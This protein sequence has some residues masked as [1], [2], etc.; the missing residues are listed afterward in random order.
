MFLSSCQILSN[1][2]FFQHHQLT[3]PFFQFYNSYYVNLHIGKEEL[4]MTK[5]LDFHNLWISTKQRWIT[6][7]PTIIVSLFLFLFLLT[8][9]G[10]RLVIMTSFLTLLFQTRHLQDFRLKRLLYTGILM[11]FICLASFLATRNLL[12]C[13]IFNLFVP[14]LVVVLLTNKFNPKAYFIYIMEF[15]FL[16]I[17]PISLKDLPKQLEALTFG[18][19]FVILALYIYSKIIKR[20]RHYGTVR[21]GMKNL[22]IQLEK[23]KNNEDFSADASALIQMMY[24]M[25]HVIYSSRNYTH[26]A[27]G[28]GKINYYF[29]LIFQRFYYFIHHFTHEE[30][31][32]C[33][34]DRDYFEELSILFASVEKNINVIDNFGLNTRL[35]H[36]MET[37]HLSSKKADEAMKEIISILIYSL[38]S[39]TKVSM[40]RHEKDWKVPSSFTPLK[41][42]HLFTNLNHFQIRFA[43]RLSIVLC[44]SFLFSF[45][46]KL[47]HAY[48]YPM[49]AFLML[50]PY[51]EESILKINNRI[52][53]TIAGSCI[54]F[55]LTQIFTTLTSHIV[56][57]LVMT[58]F[59]YAAPI[60]SWTMTMY[61]T[62]YGLSLTTLTLDREEAI[63]LRL[64][65]VGL[66]AITAFLANRFLLPNTAE[67]EFKK[68][69]HE[70]FDIDVEL[71]QEL[72][73]WKTDKPDMD[74]FR[75]LI[76]HSNLLSNEIQTYVK[77]NMKSDEQN[78]YQHLIPTHQKLI[79]EI[80]Q[81]NSFLSKRKEKIDF[82][83]NLLASELFRN[84][85]HATKKMRFNYTTNQ[86]TCP[87]NL[88]E[89]ET[90]DDNL[91]FNTIAF[92]C[93]Q[94]VHHLGELSSY[95]SNT[96][97]R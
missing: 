15:V 90:L 28:Y 61:T 52:L 55:G 4:L 80:E 83:H 35:N 11:Y 45:G 92:N 26:L 57:I 78:F 41:N 69:I 50:M 49:S 97:N 77:N 5:K 2:H 7:F 18:L 12:L 13:V 81:L 14:F 74:N 93:I 56:I 29:M 62:C 27:T 21:K 3:I 87:V 60:T 73:K 23:L 38:S 47:N 72:Q 65:Y 19:A 70:L 88:E 86:F 96:P 84:L 67:S 51:S 9:F 31:I 82:Q 66:A 22:S 94:S 6:A 37:K 32:T 89:P 53:G 64:S 10:I 43:L 40:H 71:M 63:F 59:M 1:F 75:N 39:I 44:I 54:I 8:L 95:L 20:K 58:C 48:W 76:V 46:T 24:H 25:N 79:S 16:Q 42:I 33:K 30:L 85:D 17:M 36:F 68:S 34:K 91:Y